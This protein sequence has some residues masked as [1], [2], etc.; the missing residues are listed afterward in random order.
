MGRLVLDER[1]S[2]YLMG[3]LVLDERGPCYLMGGLVLDERG[4]AADGGVLLRP[5]I[6][7]ILILDR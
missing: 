5:I 1:G 6:L 4:A 3:G 2:C 7:L